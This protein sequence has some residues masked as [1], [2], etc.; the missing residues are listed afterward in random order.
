VITAF[1]G[2]EITSSD[3]LQNAVDAKHPGDKV[4]I[5]YVRGGDKHTVQVTLGS[6]PS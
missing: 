5:T 6:R 2:Q 4:S 1:D 3:V